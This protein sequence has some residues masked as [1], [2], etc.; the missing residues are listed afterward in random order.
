MPTTNYFDTVFSM[1]VLYHRPDPLNF[2]KE[3]KS[4]LAEN[5]QLILETLVID[6]DKAYY[7]KIILE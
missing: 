4:Q 2:L 5:G 1:G 6:G 3:L 7:K